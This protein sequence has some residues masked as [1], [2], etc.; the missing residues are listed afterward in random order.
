MAWRRRGTLS[1]CARQRLGLGF[2]VRSIKKG[3][4]VDVKEEERK[5]AGISRLEIP[6]R[7]F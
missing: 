2:E 4:I 7:K 5:K 6:G 1:G 3:K